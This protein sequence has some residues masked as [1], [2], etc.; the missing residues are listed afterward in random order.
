M[1]R[2][3]LMRRDKKEIKDPDVMTAML[4]TAHVGRLGTVGHDGSPMIKPVN[5]IFDDGKLYF[6]TA[7]AGEKIEDIRRDNRVVFEVDQPIAYAKG[8]QNPCSAKYMY[9]SIIIKGRAT[10]IAE[11]AE[12]IHAL[13][14]LMKKYQ[15]EGGYGD[16]LEEKLSVTGVVRIDI[17]EMKGKQD[18]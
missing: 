17:G 14:R 1:E 4:N 16:F 10:I 8:I 2:V 15:P 9:R 13:E 5:F 7:L 12:R 18:I 6:H 3:P 11:R